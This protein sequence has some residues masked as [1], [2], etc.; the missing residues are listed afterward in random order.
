[1]KSDALTAEQLADL[2]KKLQESLKAQVCYVIYCPL[3]SN[4]KILHNALLVMLYD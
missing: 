1:M 4:V 2:N 3:L